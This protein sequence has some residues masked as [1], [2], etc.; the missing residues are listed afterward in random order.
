LWHYCFPINKNIWTSS[1]VLVTS[2]LAAMVLAISI[3]FID[4]QGHTRFLRPGIIFGSN[5]IAVYVL[6]AVWGHFF[7]ISTILEAA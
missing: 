3:F 1:F 5:A 4:I 2:G 7:I 6:A